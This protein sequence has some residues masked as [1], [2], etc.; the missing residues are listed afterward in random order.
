MTCGN[1]AAAVYLRLVTRRASRPWLMVA[2]VLA[3]CS[4]AAAPVLTLGRLAGAFSHGVGFGT[5]KPQVIDDEG[6]RIG[7]VDRVVWT[8]WGD[9]EA[10]GTD[11]AVYLGNQT[12]PKVTRQTVTVVAFGL[13]TCD[14]KLMYQ[15]V[16]WYFP[17]HGQKFD[18]NG[19]EDICAG[20]YVL[21]MVATGTIRGVLLREPGAGAAAGLPH[22]MAG[23]V[24][25]EWN[26]TGAPV[27]VT[28]TVGSNGRFSRSMVPGTYKV[29]PGARMGCAGPPPD[30][31]H[32]L[33]G[34]V[35][36]V[37]VKFAS[38]VG[39]NCRAV[40]MRPSYFSPE[41]P[42]IPFVIT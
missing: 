21:G 41:N 7:D 3:S 15:G 8:S 2:L 24:L 10:F 39:A 26:D 31:V 29:T 40:Q 4:S 18:P 5:V 28:M 22:P 23:T 25:V 9:P 37:K 33:P 34:T 13:G 17:Q 14:G 35:T 20:T 1:A 32:V 11:D 42:Y 30:T 36:S 19:Y 16:E 38:A 6:N 27:V 12:P